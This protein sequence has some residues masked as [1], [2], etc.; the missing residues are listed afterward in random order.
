F[1]T[2]WRLDL[3]GSGY[4]ENCACR[5]VDHDTGILLRWCLQ[6]DFPLCWLR[7]DEDP[8]KGVHFLRYSDGSSFCD[9]RNRWSPKDN[10]RYSAYNFLYNGRFLACYSTL[11]NGGRIGQKP[12]W[13]AS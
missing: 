7:Y 11:F 6:C 10:R 13:R 4:P 1:F 5:I 8:G 9:Y 12:L 3:L 2:H